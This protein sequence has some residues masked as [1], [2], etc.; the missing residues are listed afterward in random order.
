MW[1][2]GGGEG[3]PRHSALSKT[4]SK[5]FRFQDSLQ[6]DVYSQLSLNRHLYYKTNTWCWSQPF[7][8]NQNLYKT[9]TSIRWTTDTFKSS[10]DTCEVQ[11]VPA[12]Y[13]LGI[14]AKF[15]YVTLFNIRRLIDRLNHRFLFFLSACPP[16]P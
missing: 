11:N 6:W 4:V 7:Y 5:T 3:E 15:L 2:G 1:G 14:G 8:N 12:N 10:T 13:D 16:K 9:D